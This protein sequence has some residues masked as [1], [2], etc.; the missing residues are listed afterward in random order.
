VLQG[1]VSR[2]ID[3]RKRKSNK[4]ETARTDHG[5]RLG[6]HPPA[7]CPIRDEIEDQ[8][9]AYDVPGLAVLVLV[10]EQ[11]VLFEDGRMARVQVDGH[12]VHPRRAVVIIVRPDGADLQQSKDRSEIVVGAN[13]SA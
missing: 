6:Q 12:H 9:E 5:V 10:H 8:A 11:K 1:H 2:I 7:I 3:A 13:V 4:T